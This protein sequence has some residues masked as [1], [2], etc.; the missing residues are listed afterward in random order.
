MAR[1][2]AVVDRVMEISLPPTPPAAAGR[3][4][5]RPEPARVTLGSGRSAQLDMR[6]SRS[7]VWAEVLQSLRESKQPAYLE[8]DSESDLITEL[9]IPL[10]VTV[11]AIGPAKTGEGLTVD[12]V[13][14]HARHLLRRD[15][16]D[17][18]R[19]R[20]VLEE[21]SRTGSEVLVTESLDQHEIIDVRSPL[22]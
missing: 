2:N 4:E 18:E 7:R 12:L 20:R 17:F 5:S 13:I 10:R 19:L 21:A 1:P 22:S 9:L 14:S 15:N 16:P 3:A 11:A 6:L 8:I